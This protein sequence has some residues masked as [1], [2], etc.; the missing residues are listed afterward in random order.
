MLN[1]L[2]ASILTIVLVVLIVRQLNKNSHTPLYVTR[3]KKTDYLRSP[4]S[5]FP[6]YYEPKSNT[7]ISDNPVWL[8]F[9]VRYS[10]NS[11]S[12]NERF[13]YETKKTKDSFR[14]VTIGDSFTYGMFVNT[15]ENYSEVLEALLNENPHQSYKTFEVI[16]LGVP[17]F[18]VGFS[19]ERFRLRGEKYRPDLVVWFMNPF[20]FTFLADRRQEL[21]EQYV[22]TL[23]DEEIKEHQLQGDYKFPGRIAWAQ[24]DKEVSLDKRIAEQVEY[25]NTFSRRYRVPLLVVANQWQTW[26]DYVR[27][28]L[29][30]TLIARP[31][32]WVYTELPSLALHGGLLP[33]RHPNAKGHKLIASSILSYLYQQHVLKQGE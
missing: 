1:T 29:Q 23:T 22:A 8:G 11:D 6:H 9:S 4:T 3:L 24:M 33:D 15:Q 5:I 16:N 30:Q 17:G 2:T 27:I 31:N 10:I 14:I 26:P 13:E 20:T 7:I 19:A 12:L 21:E 25:F 28:I 18:D 32:T